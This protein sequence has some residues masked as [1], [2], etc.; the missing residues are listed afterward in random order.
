MFSQWASERTL[1]PTSHRIT[2]SVFFL[3]ITLNTYSFSASKT[4]VSE[5]N[6]EEFGRL[7][8]A[9]QKGSMTQL[10]TKIDN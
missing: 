1:V 2:K 4:S 8:E 9:I 3:F 10:I 5:R 7:S 6:D